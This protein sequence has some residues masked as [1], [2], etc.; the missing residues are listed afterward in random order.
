L[1]RTALLACDLADRVLNGFPAPCAL[2]GCV[3]QPK[4]NPSRRSGMVSFEVS[5]AEEE[6]PA[7]G[8][9][10]TQMKSDKNQSDLI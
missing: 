6:W 5:H 9:E 4:K 8:A 2:P 10:K 1:T 7:D 3:C